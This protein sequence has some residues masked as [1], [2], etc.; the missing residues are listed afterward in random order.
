MTLTEINKTII[1][2]GLQLLAPKLDTPQAR[3]LLLAIGLQESK[4]TARRQMGNGPARSFWQ[5][6]EGATISSGVKGVLNHPAS[7]DTLRRVAVSRGVAGT[8][9]AIW[10]AIERD[11]LLA[12]ALARL[13]ILTDAAPLPALGD[14][15]GAWALYALRCWR[16]GKPHPETWPGY[17]AQAFAEVAP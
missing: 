5:F 10:E 1:G 2:P 8:S 9:R 7:G 13:L 14:A 12:C 15:D 11:D 17:Y 6:E 4:F 3:V 16:P